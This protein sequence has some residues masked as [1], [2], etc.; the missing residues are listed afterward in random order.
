M[1]VLITGGNRGLGLDLVQQFGGDSIS[2]TDG[3]DITKDAK[4]IAEKSLDYDIF[5]NNAFD[6]P[7][8][9]EWANFGQVQVL[10]EVF[11]QWKAAGKQ[12]W[13]FNIGS[14]GERNIVAPEPSFET[15][16]IAKSALAHAS[17]QCTAAFKTDLVKFKTT[18]ITPDRLDTELSRSRASWTG[19]GVDCGD[20]TNF[21][22]YATT[23]NKNTCVEEIILYVN[24]NSK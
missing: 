10:L 7:P 5:I 17:R 18:L 23:I 19:N 8:Q 6:G 11:A 24:F 20:I 15:Y 14:V 13:I 16:R 22:R 2:R 12:G 21:I 4:L 3:V 9:E 1:K